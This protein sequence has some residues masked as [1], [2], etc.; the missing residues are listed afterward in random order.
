MQDEFLLSNALD[1][2]DSSVQD[3][4]DLLTEQ[5]EAAKRKK[6]AKH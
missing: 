5:E 1:T 6:P 4:R 3:H 2:L